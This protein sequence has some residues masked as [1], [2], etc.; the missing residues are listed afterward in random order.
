VRVVHP[1]ERAVARVGLDRV[2]LP[3]LSCAVLRGEREERGRT[4]QNK[5]T[6]KVFVGL[7]LPSAAPDQ[8]E[9][10]GQALKVLGS[11]GRNQV[12]DALHV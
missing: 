2:E 9:R 12:D 11:R 4:G 3:V 5:R 10:F 8:V 6:E 1:G 7:L